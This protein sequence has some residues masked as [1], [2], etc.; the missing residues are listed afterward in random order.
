MAPPY[1]PPKKKQ[2]KQQFSIRPIILGAQKAVELGVRHLGCF[3]A[4]GE[5]A[6]PT[7]E[8]SQM[9]SILDRI[10]YAAWMEPVEVC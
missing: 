5:L 4:E 9:T 6:V 1:F 8:T 2:R 7:T 3:E 10:P